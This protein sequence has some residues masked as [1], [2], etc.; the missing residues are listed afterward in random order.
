MRISPCKWQLLS[1]SVILCLALAAEAKGPVDP[2][3]LAGLQARS[4]GPAGMSGR[5]AVVAGIPGDPRIVYVGAATGG[6]WKSADGGYSFTPIF[7]EESVASIGAI[8]ID[9]RRPDIVW[10]GTGEGNLRNSVSVGN[11]VYKSLDGGKTWT[12]LGLAES[13]RIH[14]ILIDP[15][16][17]DTVYFSV[18]GKLWGDGE[19]RGVYRTRDGGLSFERVLYVAKNVGCAD[20]AMDVNNPNKLIAA[21][22]EFR[23]WPWFYES[24][25]HGSGLYISR[26]GGDNWKKLTPEDGLPEG[27]LGRMGI[28]IS[29][30]N[31]NIAYCYV[32][33]K[34]NVLLRSKDGG[35]SWSTAG[36]SDRIGN[37]PFY[38]ADLRVDPQDPDRVYSL[39][40]LVSVSEDGGNDWRILVPWSK[41]HPDH[42]AMWI[43]PLDPNR[44]IEGND[45]GI[46][47]S[48]DRGETWRFAA[49]LPVAQFY[50][51]AVDDDHPYHIY[52]GMQ[53]NGSWRGPSS[54]WE[55][56][57]IRN[58][59][60]DEVGFGDGFDTRPHPQDSM[61][62]YS[63]SQEGYLYRWDLRS[64][65]RKVIRPAAENDAQLRFNWNAG[66]AQDPFE[67]D[68]IYYGSQ[69]LHR[70]Q[71]QGDSWQTISG[72]LTSNNPKWQKQGESGGLTP[73]VTGAENFTTIVTIAPSPLEKGLLWVGSDD[74][75]A[76]VTRDGGQS[77]KRIDEGAKGVPT[78]S[79]IPHI[80]PSPHDPSVAFVVF[81]NHRRSDIDSYVYRVSDY[82]KRWKS[83]ATDEL[84]GYCLS[85]VQDPVNP[86]LLFLGT[87]FGLYVSFDGGSAWM[88]WKHGVPTVSV[89]DMVIQK[90]EGDLILG[91]H[92]RAAFVLDD[93]RPLRTMNA[94]IQAEPIHL[95]EI[96]DA[97]EYRIKQT[98]ASRFPGATEYRGENREY[99]T[100][101][102]VWLNDDELPHPD[103]ELER[104]RKERERRAAK[105]EKEED[106]KDDDEEKDSKELVVVIRDSEGH[107]VRR[108]T[109]LVHQGLNRIVWGLESD[110]FRSPG[111]DD[112]DDDDNDDRGGPEVLPGDY[113]VEVSY[114]ES[115]AEGSVTVK[116][117]PR[118]PELKPQRVKAWETVQRAGRLQEILT[119]AIE[120]VTN[121]TDD[122]DVLDRKLDERESSW[123]RDNENAK[124][125]DS[126]Q[127][128]L[129]ESAKELRKSLAK[130]DK[131]LRLP[132]DT[133]GYV[134]EEHAGSKLGTAQ[135]FLGSSWDEPTPAMLSYLGE[136]EA[137][138]REA[139][140][141]L[142]AFL[143]EDLP[144]F[145]GKVEA[146]LLELLS[147]IDAVDL[148]S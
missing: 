126:P 24:G 103:D 21:M 132:E 100:F 4:I 27:K 48:Q 18:V 33:A 34:K 94:A 12:H 40:S 35:Q 29:Q 69:F 46:G 43:D 122:M 97:Q 32:E 6:L 82:G 22:Y 60:W 28:A 56:G 62:G 78:D 86:N 13:E 133:K 15:N 58:H 81:D 52:G 113:S 65:E 44:M 136:A 127:H 66:F 51:I 30:S 95:F 145:R 138:I 55:N 102:H 88:K 11:G 19:E 85:I 129:K 109:P 107:R 20:L 9:P 14:R 25:G 125:E 137:K 47:F 10:V 99:G 104:E 130:I 74:G 128:E 84:D 93:Y 87:E 8:A 112:D 91:T 148:G 111:D 36:T 53:D 73:D 146:K 3:L 123:R 16:D 5:I 89:M 7:D 64:G 115:K 17:S 57:G 38:Y 23:R 72:D 2:T 37:R 59:H 31:S 50:H 116:A 141:A 105:D 77:W 80:E 68:T 39:W 45:G 70:S 63:M 96:A 121:V 41:L 71:D 42:H 110:P 49:N 147:G 101:I 67:S 92:G 124:D 79:W 139:V 75:R 140:E 83:L 108:L 114:G 98:G 76:H 142:N 61:R 135:W 26:D 134:F 106:D 54:V 1:C 118:A 119:A 131:L 90:R 143:A 117:D 144:D 120:R